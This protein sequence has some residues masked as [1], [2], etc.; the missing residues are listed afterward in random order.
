[1]SGIQHIVF[2][3][4]RVL[5]RWEPE[6]PFLRLIPNALDREHFLAEICNARWLLDTDLGVSWEE[7]E[8]GLIARHPEHKA[9]IRAFRQH[10]GDMVP[11]LVEGTPLILSQLIASGYDVTALTNFAS[12][13]F[14]EAFE[15]FGLLGA[16]RGITVSARCGLAK[17][18][19]AIFERH[20]ADF[21]LEPR[22][23]LFFDDA[24]AN[25]QAARRVGW[26]AEIFTGAD[27]MRRDLKRHGVK[28][29]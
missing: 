20:A 22:A 16:F 18:D 21:G 9:M 1:L 3:L 28:I 23:T 10:W 5:L 19:E 25:V 2:D 13:T 15:R 17:P 12:D 26:Q 7:A 11:G 14:D 24:P 27:A 29:D 6:L 8:R 4:G